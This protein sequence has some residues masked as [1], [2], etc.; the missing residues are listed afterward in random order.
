MA[1]I[2]FLGTGGDSIVVG[3]QMRASG[4]IVLQLE[5]NQFHLDPGPGA[6]VRAK[7]FDINIRETTA[8]F[9]SHNHINHCNDVNAVLAGMTYS[10]LD[11]RGV[12][13]CA[14]SLLEETDDNKPY[15]THYHRALVEKYI[16]LDADTKIGI[17]QINILT[18]CTEHHDPKAIG[19]KF[20]GPKYVIGYTGDT[21]YCEDLIEDHKDA[22]ILI[23]CC[24][25]PLGVK[26]KGHLNV[27]DV[28]KLAKKCKPK[29]IIITHFGIKMIEADPMQQAREIQKATQI[30]TIAAKD[31]LVVSPTSYSASVKQ[32]RLDKF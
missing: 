28:I 11:P 9:V 24:K 30:Q 29:L 27:E 23:A 31:G 17:N 32:R 4:G 26:E 2:I 8:V 12:L 14:K 13:I 7:Q 10:G 19:F 15:V 6:L 25:T 1:S 5:G 22:S 20:Y 16:G 3:K 18:T 21:D